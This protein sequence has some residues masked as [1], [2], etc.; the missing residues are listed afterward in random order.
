MKKTCIITGASSGLG[1][2]LVRD[3]IFADYVVLTMQRRPPPKNANVYWINSDF[4]D[5]TFGWK[6]QLNEWLQKH[7]TI[8]LLINNAA[9]YV[10]GSIKDNE[11][12]SIIAINL[13]S[14][15][16][17]TRVAVESMIQ[18][19]FV[20][21][22]NSVAGLYGMESEPVYSAS[23]HGLK[24]F[25][26]SLRLQLVNKG[27]NVCDL[28]PGGMNTELWNKKNPYPGPDINNTMDPRE[29]SKFI[30][31]IV[32]SPCRETFKEITLYPLQE[33]FV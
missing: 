1:A 32:N 7:G 25:A 18:G 21:N 33:K 17:L 2:A 24:G 16:V 14:P 13:I 3:L 31:N 5:T 4:T 29:I 19:S 23:K 15:I 26:K 11:V 6:S 8:D 9:Q 10:R 22:I 28:Y 30:M 20:M 12:N 27:I